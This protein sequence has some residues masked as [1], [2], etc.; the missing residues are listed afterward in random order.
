MKY[1]AAKQH[2][3]RVGRQRRTSRERDNGVPREHGLTP[4]RGGGRYGDANRCG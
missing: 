3:E 1:V 4:P 2:A